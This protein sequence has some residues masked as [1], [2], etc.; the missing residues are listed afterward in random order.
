MK[1][2]YDEEKQIDRKN[3]VAS[4]NSANSSNCVNNG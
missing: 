3:P 1:E 2:K 4:T